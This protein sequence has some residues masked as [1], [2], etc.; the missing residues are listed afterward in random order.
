MRGS[1]SPAGARPRVS[2]PDARR[3]PRAGGHVQRGGAAGG[4]RGRR[5]DRAGRRAD[6]PDVV[7]RGAGAATSSARSC[8][9]RTRSR[10]RSTRRST[11]SRV[12]A[13]DVA[14]VGEV[15]AAGAPL[16]DR[17]RGRSRSATSRSSSRTRRRSAQCARFLR[18]RAAARARGRAPRLDGRGGARRRRAR[19][20]PW[21]AIG[22]PRRG[23]A[24]RLRGPARRASRTTPTTRR[25]SSG[26]RPRP[27]R[28]PARPRPRRRRRS[29]SAAPATA[30]PGWLV[31][32]LSEFA[33]RGVNLTRIESRPRAAARRTT[34]SSW[35]STARADERVAD[36]VE[37]LRAHCEQVRV[38]GTYPSA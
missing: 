31:R 19:R 26:W 2:A 1:R 10:A 12:D 11:R 35:I 32:C 37:A 6:G 20:A 4:A 38:L 30:S 21:A 16:P 5:D 23:R 3:L 9:S 18:A 13:P 33:F 15:V 34:S 22:T 7:H 24:L 29:C 25:G 28:S 17:A 8:R 27:A 36:A 14:I